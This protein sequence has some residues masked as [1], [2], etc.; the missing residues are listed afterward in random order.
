MARGDGKILI[1]PIASAIRI[2]TSEHGTNVLIG[3]RNV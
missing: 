1:V 3:F 2:T